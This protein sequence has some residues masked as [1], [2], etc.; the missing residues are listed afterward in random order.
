MC[1]QLLGSEDHITDESHI[2]YEGNVRLGSAQVNALLRGF[3]CSKSTLR[4]EKKKKKEEKTNQKTH[5]TS[6]KPD[7]NRFNRSLP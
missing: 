4:P 3:N 5:T 6:P 1:T 2:N 7:T